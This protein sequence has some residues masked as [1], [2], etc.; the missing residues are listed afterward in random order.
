MRTHACLNNES[1][2]VQKAKKAKP[3]KPSAKDWRILRTVAHDLRNPISGIWSAS[4][5]LLEDFPD[6]REEHVALLQAINSSSRY[7][8]R[9]VDEI[10]DVSTTE[11]GP[12][13]FQ[14]QPTDLLSLVNQILDA[15]R[16]LAERNQD[17]LNLT[18]RD[19][20]PLITD[21]SQRTTSMY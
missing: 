1:T 4:E 3:D 8:L 6:A 16:M 15:N 5:Y 11:P 7:M 13:Q 20:V 21:T 14:F 17:H 19:T 10:L 12:Q 2:D 18:T 9:L